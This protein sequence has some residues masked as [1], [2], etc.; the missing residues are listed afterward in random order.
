MLRHG[1][2]VT[3]TQTTDDV[4]VAPNL[5][6]P[7]ERRGRVPPREP[8]CV[9]SSIGNEIDANPFSFHALLF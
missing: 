7:Q 4:R 3:A 5:S 1:V 8:S 9:P 2:P 6:H